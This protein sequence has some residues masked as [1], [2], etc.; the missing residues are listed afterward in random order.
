MIL[1]VITDIIIFLKGLKRRVNLTL[2]ES[3]SNFIEVTHEKH[4]EDKTTEELKI[5]NINFNNCLHI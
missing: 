1:V 5:Q 4:L 2:T 3:E